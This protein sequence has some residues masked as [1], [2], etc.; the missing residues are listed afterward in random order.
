MTLR[1]LQYLFKSIHGRGESVK[2]ERTDFATCLLDFNGKAH[3][4]INASRVSQNKERSIIVHTGDACICADL[5]AKTLEIY[6]STNLTLDLKKDN[7]YRQDGIVQ[8]I[9]VPI[10][11]PLRMELIAF[12]ESVVND[13]PIEA[14]GQVGVNAIRICEEVAERAK[15]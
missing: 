1:R 10:E 12:Y 2:S 15:K 13:A 7:S 11:E 14:D 8:K 3:A 6:K 4:I 9:Y 5:L